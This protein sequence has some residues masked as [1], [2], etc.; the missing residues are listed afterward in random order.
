MSPCWRK[1]SPDSLCR[2]AV[3]SSRFR[4]RTRWRDPACNRLRLT[5]DGRLKPCLLSDAEINVREYLRAGADDD[6][7]A[8]LLQAAVRAKPQGHRLTAAYDRGFERQMCQ[9]GG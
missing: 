5:A 9:I 8:A 4:M 3:S 2:K 1:C 6:T 7:L